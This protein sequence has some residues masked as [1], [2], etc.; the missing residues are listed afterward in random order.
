MSAYAIHSIDPIFS[1]LL[2]VQASWTG[3]I[4]A[5]L[6]RQKKMNPNAAFF[7]D[8]LTDVCTKLYFDLSAGSLK[9]KVSVHVKSAKDEDSLA[10]LIRPMLSS[11]IDYRF[12]SILRTFRRQNSRFVPLS[13]DVPQKNHSEDE[14]DA[15]NLREKISEAVLSRKM[16]KKVRQ[17]ALIFLPDRLSGMGLRELCDKHNIQ[18]GGTALKALKEIQSCAEDFFQSRKVCHDCR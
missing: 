3:Y 9:E 5:H 8:M 7:E 18:R 17:V 2:G 10:N 16:T 4:A 11:A 1:E 14:F 15:E 13:V 12:R 6:I